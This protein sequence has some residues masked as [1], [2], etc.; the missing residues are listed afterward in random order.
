M[1]ARRQAQETIIDAEYR[2][3][4]YFD[5]QW[6][7]T[8]RGAAQW[9]GDIMRTRRPAFIIGTRSISTKYA[10]GPQ[11]L[12]DKE[13]SRTRRPGVTRYQSTRRSRQ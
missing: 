13:S 4:E 7:S 8:D 10:I 1:G 11:R 2:L 9:A 3:S 12:K 6:E 5:Y